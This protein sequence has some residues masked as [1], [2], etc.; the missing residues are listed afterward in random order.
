MISSI[1]GA[2]TLSSDSKDQVIDRTKLLLETMLERNG[3]SNQVV[4]SV[5]F[6]ATSDIS[7]VAPAAGARALG[8]MAPGLLCAQ[9]MDVPGSLPLCIRCFVHVGTNTPQGDIEHVFL[10][11]AATLRPDQ[12]RPGD[13]EL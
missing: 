7:S 2:I 1:R 12:V 11:E 4:I 8:L 13:G 5:F 9:E 10:G 6:T 3:V